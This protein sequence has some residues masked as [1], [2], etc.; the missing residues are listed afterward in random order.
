[1]CGCICVCVGGGGGGE[2]GHFTLG[3]HAVCPSVCLC[4]GVGGTFH[5]RGDSLP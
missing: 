3:G 1:M 5:P 2:E 4:V